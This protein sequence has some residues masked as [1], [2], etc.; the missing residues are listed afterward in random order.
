MCFIGYSKNPKG[1]R[2]IDLNTNKV[3]T[4]RDVVFNETDFHF[5]KQTNV[6]GV[7][8][9]PELLNEPEETIEDEPQSVAPPRRSQ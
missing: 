8:I 7:S 4:K 1:Y 3:A 6:E 9:S 5:S 2:L